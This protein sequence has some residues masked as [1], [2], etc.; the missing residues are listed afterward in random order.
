MPRADATVVEV[1]IDGE[2]QV[3]VDPAFLAE[4]RD[5]V[6][7]IRKHALAGQMQDGQILS[8]RI[9]VSEQ[10]R[11]REPAQQVSD[12]LPFS[13]ERLK[14]LGEPV[15]T[16][17]VRVARSVMV[18]ELRIFI[19]P[20]EPE[21]LG[22]VLLMNQPDRLPG[23]FNLTDPNDSVS[24]TVPGL[25]PSTHSNSIRSRREPRVIQPT[26]S[27]CT[28]GRGLGVAGMPPTAL[29]NLDP[30]PLTRMGAYEE[31]WGGAVLAVGA[32]RDHERRP[33]RDTGPPPGPP[34][35]REENPR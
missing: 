23:A 10:H 33:A 29:P 15:G 28:T 8:V 22:S 21:R 19:D 13:L 34:G 5:G 14:K 18:L 9:V 12:R 11:E 4:I 30:R 17:T 24:V 7:D 25:Y 32:V 27:S 1:A 26:R 20:V 16:R 31:D 6:I 3:T 35:T 2:R